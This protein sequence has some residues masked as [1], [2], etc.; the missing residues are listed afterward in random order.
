MGAGAGLVIAAGVASLILAMGIRQSFGIFLTP[1]AVDLEIG[2]QAFGL[3]IAVQ[4]LLWGLA[5]PVIG[6]IADRYGAMRVT[7]ASALLYAVGLGLA[8]LAADPLGLTL[9]LGVVVGMAL[10]GTTYVTVLGAVGRVVPPERRS[11]AFGICTAAGSFGMF[12]VVP[13][14]QALLDSFGWKDAFVLMAIGISLLVPLSLGFR[15]SDR[16]IAPK[17][18]GPGMGAAIREAREHSGYLLLIAGFFVCGFHVAF[19]ATH[20]PA[21]L[22][23]RGLPLDVTAWSLAMIGLFNI[24]GSY[25]AGMAGSRY[26][27]K[28]VLAG[29]YLARAVVI[30]LFVVLPVTP[31]TAIAFGA[32]IGFL[33]LSTVPLTSGLVAQM[34]GVRYLS[35]LYGVVF[36]SH[37]V[38]AFLG[39]WGGGLAYDLLGSYD[40]IWYASIVLALFAGL[41]HLPIDDRPAVRAPQ[42]A[43]P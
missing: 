27:Q 4:Q 12:A 23:D 20:L 18:G 14:A 32:G 42:P 5:Q 34:F 10:T 38:G 1:I 29:I 30:S 13:G 2:R 43:V 41:I 37:Q 7:M 6:A 9:T 11:M 17:A 19:V 25:L 39:A 33:W 8:T 35:T 26:R 22:S 31:F 28:N 21:F 3:A 24:F 15:G 16:M 36:A 40:A